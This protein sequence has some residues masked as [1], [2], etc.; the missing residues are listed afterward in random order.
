[1]DGP[2]II[3]YKRTV[4]R[5]LRWPWGTF[6]DTYSNGFA[7]GTSGNVGESGVAGFQRQMQID[8]TGWIGKKTFNFLRSVKVPTGSHA[9][10][11][12]MDAK[13][14]QLINQAYEQ[15]QG[16]EPPPP[17]KST[18]R[19]KAL[20]RAVTQIGVRESPPGSNRQK[21]GEWYGMNGVAWCAIFATFC[22]DSLGESPSF[23][24]GRNYAYVPYIVGDARAAR[25]GLLVTG[26]PIPG[27]LVC[28]DWDFNGEHDH[29]GLFERWL[30][31]S[32]N[33]STVEGN[34][35]YSDY[36]NGGQVMRCTRNSRS[37][38]TVFVRVAEPA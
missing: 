10:E 26:S 31:S 22:Y 20:A 35:G 9:G 34:T 14:I 6:D 21:Y 33:F 3:A 18:V 28:Y 32:G 15:F 38:G 24:K 37:Q 7:H 5:A 4:S 1:V 12:A 11:F 27:D 17:P 23:V 19:Q 13:A 29:V 25:N 36:S 16:H 8:A 30:D 2:D